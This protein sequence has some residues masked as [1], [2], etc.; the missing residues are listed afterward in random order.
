MLIFTFFDMVEGF[1]WDCVR[2][3]LLEGF[4]NVGRLQSCSLNDL[5]STELQLSIKVCE[6][7]AG[8]TWRDQEKW[9]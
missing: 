3:F 2:W 8:N 4:P 6:A 7:S 1:L 9:P 5:A